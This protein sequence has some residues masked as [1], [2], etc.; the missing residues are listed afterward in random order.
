[1]DSAEPTNTSTVS[2]PSSVVP[3]EITFTRGE[4][5]ASAR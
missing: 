1:M 3:V 4:A 2:R 5:A